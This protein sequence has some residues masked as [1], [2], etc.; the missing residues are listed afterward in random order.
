[1]RVNGWE[2]TFHFSGQNWQNFDT[3]KQIGGYTT[4]IVSLFLGGY[5]P[6]VSPF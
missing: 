3:S 4:P 1:M 6:I 5:T 2:N